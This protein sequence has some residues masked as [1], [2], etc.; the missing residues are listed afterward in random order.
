MFCAQCGEKTTGGL[1]KLWRHYERQHKEID[2]D[3]FKSNGYLL[4]GAMPKFSKFSNFE[5]YLRNLDIELK[6]A[7]GYDY[8]KDG[9]LS[10]S[11]RGSLQPTKTSS[12]ADD[13]QDQADQN[14]LG[15]CGL[16]RQ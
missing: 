1:G 13:D 4:H 10:I 9:R 12:C 6:I 15:P 2:F 16:K 7:E 5:D 14:S 11:S 8:S 3:D